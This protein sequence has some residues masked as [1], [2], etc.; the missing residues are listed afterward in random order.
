[1]IV[2]RDSRPHVQSAGYHSV[3]VLG[4]LA[5]F[6]PFRRD[7]QRRKIRLIFF[8]FSSSSFK[9]LNDIDS[10]FFIEWKRRKKIYRNTGLV[11]LSLRLLRY[12]E[13]IGTW[14]NFTSVRKNR[15]VFIY[16]LISKKRKLFRK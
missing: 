7:R 14:R 4:I 16:E 10:N 12:K 6:L 9:A 11:R 2:S 3:F 5:A 15:M 13:A 8:V 1:M